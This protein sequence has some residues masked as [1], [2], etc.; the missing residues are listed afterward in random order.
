MTAYKITDKRIRDIAG[1]C[2]DAREVMVKHYPEAF[3]KKEPEWVDITKN[4]KWELEKMFSSNSYYLTGLYNNSQ[5]V[6]Q[7]GRAQG[8]FVVI[9]IHKDTIKIKYN[10]AYNFC[11]LEKVDR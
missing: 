6:C 8:R 2:S 9:D 5:I 10:K 3:E 7:W 11:I 4:I 1:I